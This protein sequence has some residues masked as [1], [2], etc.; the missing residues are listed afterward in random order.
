MLEDEDKLHFLIGMVR[1]SFRKGYAA[2]KRYLREVVRLNAATL[3]HSYCKFVKNML[4]TV[5][6]D[7]LELDTWRKA[8]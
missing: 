7:I 6:L 3:A 5:P 1:I 8:I 2:F 4:K